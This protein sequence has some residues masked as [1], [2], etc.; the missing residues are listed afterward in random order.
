MLKIPNDVILKGKGE[1]KGKGKPLKKRW[2]K[3]L[4]KSFTGQFRQRQK[5][6]LKEIRL[7]H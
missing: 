7:K 4:M 1:D 5:L 6:M 2:E 3:R